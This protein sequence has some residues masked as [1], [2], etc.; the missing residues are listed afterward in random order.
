VFPGSVF[1]NQAPAGSKER[2]MKISLAPAKPR[3]PLVAA[4]H[5]RAAG[6]HR[7]SQAAQRQ[8]ANLALRRELQH[9]HPPH[10]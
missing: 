10:A 4:A 6:S 3:N 2:P 9:E 8:R 1:I 5:R 7:R